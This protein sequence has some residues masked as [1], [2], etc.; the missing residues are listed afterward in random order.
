MISDLI[1]QLNRATIHVNPQ[2]L[3]AFLL[4]L[5]VMATVLILAVLIR[6]IKNLRSL[7][8]D[9]P[10]VRW[11]VFIL[12]VVLLVGQIIPVLLDSIVAFGSTYAGRS[13]NPN[14]I[15]ASYALN[16]AIKDVIIG[17]LLCFLYFRPGAAR[18]KTKD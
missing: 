15:G 1:D 14:I 3:A 4:G 13:T 6:Q 18:L 16:N 5:R 17:L 12:T 7:S 9:Y 2:T 10:A 11:T 8:T